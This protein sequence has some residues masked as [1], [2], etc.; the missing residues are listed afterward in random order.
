MYAFGIPATFACVV[1]ALALPA[2]VVVPAGAVARA[3]PAATLLLV[4]VALAVVA[5]G[6]LLAGAVAPA[7]LDGA[8]AGAA[9]A[10]VGAFVG[11]GMS[12]ALL[13]PPQAISAVM[14]EVETAS[15]P[16]RNSNARRE[17]RPRM[18]PETLSIG[19]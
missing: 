15:A 5:A 12:V 1:G 4:V 9:G 6:A 14:A 3:V 11:A 8:A 17:S 13:L 16:A 10:V 7:A 2:A 19:L 18:I